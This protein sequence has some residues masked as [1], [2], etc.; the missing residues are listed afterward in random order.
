MKKICSF[1]LLL[2]TPLTVNA[3]YIYSGVSLVER[4]AV[5]SRSS[6]PGDVYI[7][8]A[9]PP[10]ECS[11][12]YYVLVDSPN[13]QEILSLVLSAYHSGSPIQINAFNEPKWRGS[14]STKICEIEGVILGS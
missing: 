12:G 5:Y 11:D 13:K 7:K 14:S 9:N 1:V 2:A 8:L 3:A 6:A 4:I 10:A